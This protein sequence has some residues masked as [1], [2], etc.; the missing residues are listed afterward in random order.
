MYATKYPKDSRQ[1]LVKPTLDHLGLDEEPFGVYFD[2]I[3][4]EKSFGPKPG[5]PISRELED[6]GKVDMQAV[7]FA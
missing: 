6:Q 5:V 4:P 7:N 2:D 1:K 3:K